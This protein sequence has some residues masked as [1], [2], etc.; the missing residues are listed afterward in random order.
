MKTELQPD[1]A[2]ASWWWYQIPSVASEGW[3]LDFKLCSQMLLL[4][5]VWLLQFP[6]LGK[7]GRAR[8]AV[9][10]QSEV[11]TAVPTVSS[12]EDAPVPCDKLGIGNSAHVGGLPVLGKCCCLPLGCTIFWGWNSGHS[13]GLHCPSL[14]LN[15]HRWFCSLWDSSQYRNFIFFG[16]LQLCKATV[17]SLSDAEVLDCSIRPLQQV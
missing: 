7:G 4:T 6:A 1:W 10:G 14:V 3:G 2:I 16:K 13:S 8:G 11:R 5:S 15:T 17:E 12:C 9:G